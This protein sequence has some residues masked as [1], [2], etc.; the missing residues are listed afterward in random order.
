MEYLDAAKI[1][2]LAEQELQAERVRA[3]IDAEKARLRSRKGFW[4]R[5]FPYK[6]IIIR[7]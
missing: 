2:L 6:L 4:R 7:R 5:V 1:R 3:A